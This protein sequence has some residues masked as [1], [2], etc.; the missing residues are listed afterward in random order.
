MIMLFSC[1]L[2][3]FAKFTS[4]CNTKYRSS[5]YDSD[6]VFLSRWKWMEMAGIGEREGKFQEPRKGYSGTSVS[7]WF[8]PQCMGWVLPASSFYS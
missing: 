4:V 7:T 3:L 6:M 8:L 1:S 5:V 2:Y